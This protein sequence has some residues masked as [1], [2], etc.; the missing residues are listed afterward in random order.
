MEGKRRPGT[1]AYIGRPWGWRKIL[2]SMDSGI[3]VSSLSSVWV[4]DVF[5]IFRT[6]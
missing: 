2:I 3:G 5:E 4:F 6:C 1:W